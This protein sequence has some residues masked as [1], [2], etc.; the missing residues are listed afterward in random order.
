TCV[1]TP[2]SVDGPLESRTGMVSRHEL[3]ACRVS[4]V[5]LLVERA[6]KACVAARDALEFRTI[7]M[8]VNSMHRNVR[9]HARLVARKFAPLTGAPLLAYVKIW[10]SH[11]HRDTC[12]WNFSGDLHMT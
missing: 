8:A 4:A 10:L 5:R 7:E 3:A 11:F 1:R 9:I 2:K 6:R 12:R